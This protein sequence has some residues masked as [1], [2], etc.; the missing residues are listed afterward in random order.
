MIWGGLG[1][2]HCTSSVSPKMAFDN[3]NK[4][5][6]LLKPMSFHWQNRLFVRVILQQVAFEMRKV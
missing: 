1:Q 3:F 4:S 6:K 2:V 5:F